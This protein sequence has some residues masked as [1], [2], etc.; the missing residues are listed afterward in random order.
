MDAFWWHLNEKLS[1]TTLFNQGQH[2]C[3]ELV[4][5]LEPIYGKLTVTW[6]DGTQS[7]EKCHRVS[8]MAAHKAVQEVAYIL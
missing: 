7:V 8:Y 3:T 5:C 1:K 4:G 6:P 2:Q